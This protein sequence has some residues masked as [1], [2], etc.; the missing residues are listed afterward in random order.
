[1]GF[2]Y[3]CGLRCKTPSLVGRFPES[4]SIT[5][6]GNLRLCELKPRDIVNVLMKLQDLGLTSRGAGADN[7]RNITASPTSGFDVQELLDV[8]PFAKVMH[9]YILNNCKTVAR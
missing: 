1:M 5:T 9:H 2:I 4:L 8:R 7:V 3:W 6:R